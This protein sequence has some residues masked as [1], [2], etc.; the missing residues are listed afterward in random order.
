M[1]SF[2]REH[3]SF[4][5]LVCRFYI[6]HYAVCSICHLCILAILLHQFCVI[7]KKEYP[8]HIEGI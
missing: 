2:Y 7:E 6:Y 4:C 3:C 1:L 5:I 8:Y